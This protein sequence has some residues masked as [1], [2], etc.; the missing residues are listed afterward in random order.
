M[1]GWIGR[2]GWELMSHR[3]KV[4]NHGGT[5][6]RNT[7]NAWVSGE[8]DNT[9]SPLLCL[10]PG[11]LDIAHH[12]KDYWFMDFLGL[13]WYLSFSSLRWFLCGD[14]DFTPTFSSSSG[15]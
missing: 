14:E 3:K 1:I 15:Y 9:C 10:P 8:E 11:I 6:N 7:S 12:N 13:L 5:K 4:G 2:G